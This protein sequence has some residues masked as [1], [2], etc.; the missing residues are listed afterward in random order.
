MPM[1]LPLER[2]SSPVNEHEGGIMMPL[3]IILST[4]YHVKTMIAYDV[5]IGL[6][7]LARCWQC[8]HL[9]HAWFIPHVNITVHPFHKCTMSYEYT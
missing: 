1:C 5:N 6:T 8:I 7:D 9:D 3:T 4:M 2:T